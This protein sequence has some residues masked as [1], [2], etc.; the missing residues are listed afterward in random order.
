M[1]SRKPTKMMARARATSTI[2]VDIMRSQYILLDF[3]T[4][5]QIA[6]F[7]GSGVERHFTNGQPSIIIL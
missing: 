5:S 4:K 3:I 6:G 1:L 7:F 2:L